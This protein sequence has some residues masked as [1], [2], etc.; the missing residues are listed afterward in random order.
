MFGI[1]GDAI[2]HEL[3]PK[4]DLERTVELVI[5]DALIRRSGERAPEPASV[6]SVGRG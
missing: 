2:L 4:D 1:T 5:V 6:P 3:S